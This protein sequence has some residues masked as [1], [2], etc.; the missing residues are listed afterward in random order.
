MDWALMIHQKAMKVIQNKWKWR[1]SDIVAWPG[2]V[3]EGQF[4][5][6]F[7]RTR[8]PMREERTRKGC[9]LSAH[10]HAVHTL[11]KRRC[12][13]FTI[14][15]LHGHVLDKTLNQQVYFLRFGWAI[16]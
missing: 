15:T 6:F 12:G 16:E 1:V 4:P 10:T 9:I 14:Y 7:S 13:S 11:R 2:G 3:L 5:H 8:R